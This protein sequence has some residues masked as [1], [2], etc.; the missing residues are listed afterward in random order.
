MSLQSLGARRHVVGLFDQI[1]F[2][3]PAILPLFLL[4]HAVYFLARL[5]YLCRSDVRRLFLAP[6]PPLQQP[7]ISLFLSF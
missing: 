1:F 2:K 6:P 5:E 4:Q 3:L 7:F